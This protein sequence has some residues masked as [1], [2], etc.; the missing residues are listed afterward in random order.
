MLFQ[1]DGEAHLKI[2]TEMMVT[3][4]DLISQLEDSELRPILPLI[5]PTVQSLTAHAHDPQ[6][7]QVVAEMLG[8]VATLYGFSPCE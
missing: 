1:Q 7:R 4:F 5:F 6:L 8:R 2:W 3:V